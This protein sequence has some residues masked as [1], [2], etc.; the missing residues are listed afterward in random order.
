MQQIGRL[1]DTLV[2]TWAAAVPAAEPDE[3]QWPLARHVA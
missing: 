3:P 2:A 1:C